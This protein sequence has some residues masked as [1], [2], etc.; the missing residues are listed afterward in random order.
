MADTRY[1]LDSN[2]FMTAVRQ[3]YPF[4]LVPGFWRCLEE[5]A[6][7]GRVQSI[8]HVKEELLRGKDDL[9][10]WA[11][12]V[13]DG[14]FAPTSDPDVLAVFGQIMAWAQSQSQ[15]MPAAKA[16]FAGCADGWL[17]A[18]AKVHGFVVVT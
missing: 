1:L 14:A 8:D 10:D 12:N 18:Y 5:H 16:E 6:K 15:F 9:A 7:T 17:V 4:D 13:F 3:Y 2:I 11:K